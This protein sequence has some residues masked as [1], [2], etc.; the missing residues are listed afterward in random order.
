MVR[1]RQAYQNELELAFPSWVR[2]AARAGSSN[3]YSTAPKKCERRVRHERVV[4]DQDAQSD[5]SCGRSE[6]WTE[7]ATI[8][9]LWALTRFSPFT[10]SGVEEYGFALIAGIVRDNDA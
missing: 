3:G 6:S 5:R 4:T 9:S 7:V 8:P 1:A 2:K 10:T